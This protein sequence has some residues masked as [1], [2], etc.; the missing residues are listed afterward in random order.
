[1][2]TKSPLSF[3]EATTTP[4]KRPSARRRAVK[5]A[6][7]V[8]AVDAPEPT[9]TISSDPAPGPETI[10]TPAETPM[11]T[12]RTHIIFSN[13]CRRCGGMPS[14]VGTLLGVMVA[15]VIGLSLATISTLSTIKAQQYQI[16]VLNSPVNQMRF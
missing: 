6:P 8:M 10:P 5:R 4:R 16:H 9:T 7:R 12:V 11:K 15:L 3:D 13:Q 1:M 2:P 14:R